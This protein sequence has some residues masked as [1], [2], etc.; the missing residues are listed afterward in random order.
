MNHLGYNI[1]N[2]TGTPIIAAA[3][4]YVSHA[5]YMGGYGNVVILTYSINGQ[6]H[7]TVYAHLNSID[8]A[9]GQ[10]VTQGEKLGGMGDTGRSF[11]THLHFE[12]HIGPW[13]GARSNAVNPAPYLE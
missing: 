10:A 2:S 4:G 6:V 9:V 13:N 8:V 5:R 3:A 11:G 7:S 12:V 1:A